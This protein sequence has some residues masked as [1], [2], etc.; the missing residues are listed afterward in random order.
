MPI[1]IAIGFER[2]GE[3]LAGAHDIDL[4]F[5]SAPLIENLP[6]LL[7]LTEIWNVNFQNHASR[8]VVPYAD[9]L[10]GLPAYLQQL[11]MESNGKSVD[12]RG[13]PVDYATAPVVWG[14]VGTPVQ[15]AGFQALYQGTTAI[16]VDFIGIVDHGTKRT[17]HSRSLHANMLAQ[18]AALMLGKTTQA[19][20]SELRNAGYSDEEA[21]R[22]APHQAYPGDRPSNTIL[23]D[24]LDP[25]NLGALIALYEHKVFV[26]SVIWHINPFDQWGVEWG[27]RL[28]AEIDSALAGNATKRTDPATARSIA[29]IRNQ[30]S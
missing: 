29:R 8:A 30:V 2:F 20:K 14:A 16:P 1:A 19:R 23:L 21:A 17:A 13:N 28:A 5:R 4:H 24:R 27:K 3:L 7:A 9:A 25:R 10:A 6:A 18:A 12:R 11:E 26:E 15:H 22:L